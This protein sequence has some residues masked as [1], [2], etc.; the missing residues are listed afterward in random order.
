MLYQKLL[1]GLL[2][3]LSFGLNRY[4][5]NAQS[6][7]RRFIPSG[8]EGNLVPPRVSRAILQQLRGH[9]RSTT[10]HQDTTV[11]LIFLS[12]Q[13]LLV[14]LPDHDNG[15]IGIKM[16]YHLFDRGSSDGLIPIN[17][18]LSPSDTAQSIL[19]LNTQGQLQIQI[20]DLEVGKPRPT[21][22]DPSATILEKISESTD[23][24]STLKVVELNLKMSPPI[25]VQYINILAQY[26][27]RFY[28]DN[29]KF[30]DNLDELGLAGGLETE[31]YTYSMKKDLNNVIIIQAIPKTGKLI[32]Y[33]GTILLQKKENQLTPIM[34]ICQSDTPSLIPPNSAVLSSKG[35]I[36]CPTGSTLFQ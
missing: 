34:A 10:L 24:P 17:L 6:Q 25:A 5:V 28:Q 29:K 14:I 36:E 13:Q 15:S 4:P 20:T 23:I 7:F 19:Q 9:W 31:D 32:S 18:I 3:G 2:L 16:G 33:T 22:F 1:I 21:V 12:D 30:A 27:Q 8:R 11:E 26:Q 35:M